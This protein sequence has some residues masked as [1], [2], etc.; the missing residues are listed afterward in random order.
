MAEEH[1]TIDKLGQEPVCYFHQ[2]NGER[3]EI[4]KRPFQGFQWMSKKLDSKKVHQ[5]IIAQVVRINKTDDNRF[6]WHGLEACITKKTVERGRY[7]LYYSRNKKSNKNIFGNWVYTPRLVALNEASST[8]LLI[9]SCS[10]K[11]A[12]CL[13]APIMCDDL[14]IV[15]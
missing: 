10:M 14:S 9:I 4:S 11:D 8:F 6:K 7:T 1:L 15:K 12:H 5:G 3:Y 13:S 2:F